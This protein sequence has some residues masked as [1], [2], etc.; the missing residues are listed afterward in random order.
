VTTRVAA[1]RRKRSLYARRALAKGRPGGAHVSAILGLL[2]LGLTIVLG[3]AACAPGQLSPK[4]AIIGQWVNSRGGT[5]YFYADRSGF[6]PGDEGQT[7]AIPSVSFTY[8]FEDETHLAIELDGQGP[9]IVE[10]KLEGDTMI[11]YAPSGGTEFV[12]TRAK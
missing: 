2:I 1:N 11:W 12:Y 10:I 9:L 3:L 4:K 8:Y 5:V 7:P 6:I